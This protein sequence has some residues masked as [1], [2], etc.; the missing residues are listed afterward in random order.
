[1]DNTLNV[2]VFC[3]DLIQA[4]FVC[5]INLVEDWALSA[6]K[7]YAVEGDLGGVVE[8]VND[9]DLV[10]MFEESETG[11]G[12]NVAGASAQSIN[13]YLNSTCVVGWWGRGKIGDM[14]NIPGD[15]NCSKSHDMRY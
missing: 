10:A 7:L 14:E 8:T 3:E 4:S 11:E 5:N 9:D 1:V 13:Q 2:R 15:K 12:S 6:E